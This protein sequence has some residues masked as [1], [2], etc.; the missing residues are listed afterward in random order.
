MIHKTYDSHEIK[1]TVEEKNNGM[2][3][4]TL[5]D[6]I[7]REEFDRKVFEFETFGG[8]MER[9]FELLAMAVDNGRA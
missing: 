8:A 6:K 5:W 1:I 2:Y 4:A 7:D 9:A 3:I